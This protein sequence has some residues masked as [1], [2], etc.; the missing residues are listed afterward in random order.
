MICSL[1][2]SMRPRFRI[3]RRAAPLQG[4]GKAV[5]YLHASGERAA[6]STEGSDET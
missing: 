1:V 2:R 3:E 5:H 6:S 4:S